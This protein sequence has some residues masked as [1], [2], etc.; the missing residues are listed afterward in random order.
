MNVLK[1]IA[2]PW[3]SQRRVNAT[4]TIDPEMYRAF[5][6]LICVELNI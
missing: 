4:L 2:Q 6:E 3:Q 5:C 1:A